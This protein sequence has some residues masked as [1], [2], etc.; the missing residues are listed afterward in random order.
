MK[1][2]NVWKKAKTKRLGSRV[3]N[4]AKNSDHVGLVSQIL[5]L[6]FW[7]SLVK[8]VGSMESNEEDAQASYCPC[9]VAVVCY[10]LVF[11]VIV[12][13][14]KWSIDGLDMRQIILDTF[15]SNGSVYM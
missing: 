7:I 15:L 9:G 11:E 13:F 12:L 2:E 8:F 1:F 14:L 6:L 10:C 5:Y 3:F 4:S